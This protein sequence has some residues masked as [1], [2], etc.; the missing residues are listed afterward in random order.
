MGIGAFAAAGAARRSRAVAFGPCLVTYGRDYG[1]S[2]A[3]RRARRRSSRTSRSPAAIRPRAAGA[4][5]RR[6]RG[7]RVPHVP[8][9]RRA[10]SSKAGRRACRRRGRRRRCPD[11]VAV[12]VGRGVRRPSWSRPSRPRCSRRRPLGAVRGRRSGAWDALRPARIGSGG[13]PGSLYPVPLA[14]VRRLLR[15]VAVVPHVRRDGRAGGR[16]G[17]A[18]RPRG[19]MWTLPM[20]R[21]IV[22]LGRVDRRCSTS[23]PGP[24]CTSQR[25]TPRTGCRSHRLQR[26]DGSCGCGSIER[27]RR[28]L[29]TASASGVGRTACRR[30]ARCSP[31]A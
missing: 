30:R 22:D 11:A 25:G 13:G 4:V 2:A 29:P 23:S 24:S 14:C 3:T 17:T 7:G 10:R 16:A 21:A 8:R 31:A 9:R 5:R 28:A 15:S 18:G 26:D 20:S 19:S 6:W 1:R 12:A 27:R